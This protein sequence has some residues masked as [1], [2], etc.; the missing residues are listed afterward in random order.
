MRYTRQ[1]LV[2]CVV[3]LSSSVAHADFANHAAMLDKA[4]PLGSNTTTTFNLFNHAGGAANP[5]AYG[6]RLDSFDSTGGPI[7]F[8]FQDGMGNSTVQLVV[9]EAIDGSI[10]LNINGTVTG[11]SADGGLDYGTFALD[12][13][14]IVD[15]SGAGWEDNNMS[16]GTLLGGLT[17]LSTTM[18]SPLGDGAFFELFGK[19]DGVDAFRFLADGHR[20]AGDTSTWVGRGWVM[21]SGSSSSGINDLLFTAQIV[22]L[23]PA[24]IGGLAMLTG[25][26]VCR[27]LRA[28]KR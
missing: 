24:A 27:R 13:T 18:S 3:G 17:G 14:Y 8:S 6:L 15:A 20:L 19:S 9:M 23:P 26:G 28:G 2:T 25:L 12:L 5:Q 16:D 22:P 4:S 1:L 11:N 7:T 21:G 10:S